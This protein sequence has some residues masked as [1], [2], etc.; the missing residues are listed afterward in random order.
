MLCLNL[1]G[2]CS[3]DIPERP[4]LSLRDI[5]EQSISAS[6]DGMKRARRNGGKEIVVKM[7]KQQQQQQKK[8]K[9]NSNIRVTDYIM[10]S[11]DIIKENSL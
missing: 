9:A 6:G 7:R 10:V 3:I 8:I 1:L 4:S 5:E 11:V 2:L